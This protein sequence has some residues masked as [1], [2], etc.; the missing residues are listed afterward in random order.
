MLSGG[1]KR[2]WGGAA[3][4]ASPLTLTSLRDTR[5]P[6]A[7]RGSGFPDYLSTSRPPTLCEAACRCRNFFCWRRPAP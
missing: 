3:C 4:Y 6:A 5:V 1:L 2:T 7:G